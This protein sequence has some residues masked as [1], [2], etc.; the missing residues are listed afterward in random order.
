MSQ[1]QTDAVQKVY[2]NSV[3]VLGD[4]ESTVLDCRGMSKFVF[5][6]GAYV[7]GIGTLAVSATAEKFKTTTTAT[8]VIAGATLTKAATDLLVFSAA[9]TINVGTAVGDYWG[10]WLVQINAAGTISTKSVSADQAY[11]SE[12]LA[13]AALPDPDSGNVALGYI[14]VQANTDS[15]WTANTDDLTAA[16]DCQDVNF[17]DTSCTVSYSA[18]DSESATAHIGTATTANTLG[19]PVSVD[20]AWPFYLVSV[21]GL[22]GARVAIV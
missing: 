22:A 16:S 20:V 1:L 8:F 13:I 17:V 6:P 9:D 3:A 5:V 21:S 10:A 18:V 15:S 7:R 12:V 19:T 14:T 4:G 2:L 11:A